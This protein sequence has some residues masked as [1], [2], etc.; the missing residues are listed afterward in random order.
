MIIWKIK[1]KIQIINIK[2]RNFSLNKV[3]F[4]DAGRLLYYIILTYMHKVT[5]YTLRN[6]YLSVYN[7]I[8]NIY[9]IYVIIKS[10]LN[11]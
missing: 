1:L 6:I 11:E 10:I 8:Y 2:I 7:D 5:P 4:I 3:Y 9:C